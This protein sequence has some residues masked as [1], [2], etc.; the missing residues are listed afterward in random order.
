MLK[1]CRAADRPRICYLQCPAEV[2]VLHLKRFLCSKYDI[3]AE[4][5]AQV[6]VEI[7]YEDEVL[8]P[9]FRLMD[10]GYCYQWKRVSRERGK[11]KREREEC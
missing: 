6:E 10:V 4:N 9:S 5:N 1:H 7:T 2:R 8:P 3:D 11:G